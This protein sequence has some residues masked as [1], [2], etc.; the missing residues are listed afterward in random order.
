M[1]L[2]PLSVSQ[3]LSSNVLQNSVHSCTIPKEDRF[4]SFIKNNSPGKFYNLPQMSN[5][6]STSLGVGERMKDNKK[7]INEPSPTSYNIPCLNE[8]LKNKIFTLKSKLPYKV[9]NIYL[10]NLGRRISEI[11]WTRIL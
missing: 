5:N 1:S 7:F 11:P 2:N 9:M 10:R 3:F 6:R 8:I 4:K